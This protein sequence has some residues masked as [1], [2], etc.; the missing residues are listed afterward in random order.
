VQ[1]RDSCTYMYYH[2]LAWPIPAVFLCEEQYVT[3]IQWWSVG[4]ASLPLDSFQ[5]S[6][7]SRT[8][9][10]LKDWMSHNW[11]L[12]ASLSP[13]EVDDA[14][15]CI[16]WGQECKSWLD[17]SLAIHHTTWRQIT[18]GGWRLVSSEA[19]PRVSQLLIPSEAEAAIL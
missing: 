9:G 18:E 11:V 17:D 10:N 2:T 12:Y 8:R 5:V 3:N 7:W 13:K 15:V 16:Q 1:D 6:M 4:T 19:W 14:T